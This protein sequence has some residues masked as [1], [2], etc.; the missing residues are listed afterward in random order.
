MPSR[1]QVAQK[2]YELSLPIISELGYELVDVEYKKEGTSFFLRVYIFKK[3]GVSIDDCERISKTLDPVFEQGLGVIPDFFEVSSPGLDR[4]LKTTQD[5]L[6][7][8]DEEVDVRLYRPFE[9]KKKF[10]G[11]IVDADDQGLIIQSDGS[12][13]KIPSDAISSVKRMI[14]FK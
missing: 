13:L 2:A 11:I 9:G 3:G 14:R 4:P 10:V 6:R 5:F 1:G 7:H 12:S 8:K